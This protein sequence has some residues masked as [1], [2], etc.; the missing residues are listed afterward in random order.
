MS[1]G[2]KS[3]KEASQSSILGDTIK[4][5][6]EL[7]IRNCSLSF[8]ISNSLIGRS[9][10]ADSKEPKPDAP[11]PQGIMPQMIESLRETRARL[12]GSN[13]DLAEV[14]KELQT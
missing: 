5:I 13:Q 12:Q 8:N 4:D 7:S 6:Q 9:P 1:D 10:T 3:A 2:A 14:L 11:P